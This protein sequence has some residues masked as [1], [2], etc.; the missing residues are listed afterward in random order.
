MKIRFVALAL[1]ALP[2]V[3]H[4]ETLDI[5]TGAWEVTISTAMSG[6]PIPKEAMAK[7]SPEQRA[8]MEASMRAQ[9][10]QGKPHISRSC[11]TREDIDRGLL[12]RSDE[13]N[14]KRKVITQNAR[15]LEMEEVCT[16]P[17]PSKSHF[18]VDATSN[19][20]YTG[21]IDTTRG[22]GKVHVDMSGRWIAATCTKGVDD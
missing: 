10:G 5:K 11:V 7:M 12:M 1:V 21:S 4:A 20:R 17:E 8:R 6:M 3:S 9:A 15:H 16:G 18:K 14:C 13:P 2:L 22:D 19:E